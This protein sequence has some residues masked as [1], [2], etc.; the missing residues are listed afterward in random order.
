MYLIASK[1]RFI[2]TIEGERRILNNMS[3]GVVINSYTIIIHALTIFHPYV[4][5]TLIGPLQSRDRA[6]FQA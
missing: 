3:E 5:R 2:T 1:G 4:G 6:L